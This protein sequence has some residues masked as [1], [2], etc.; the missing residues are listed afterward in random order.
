MNIKPE[1][2]LLTAVLFQ[3]IKD[4]TKPKYA[5]DA[6]AFVESDCF[7]WIWDEL[8]EDAQRMPDVETV[9]QMIFNGDVS[10]PRGAYH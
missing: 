8:S 9:R 6:H 3:T 5:D 4:S 1:K 10:V 2:D 7:D